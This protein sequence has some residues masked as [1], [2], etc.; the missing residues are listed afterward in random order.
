MPRVIDVIR[1]LPAV[2]PPPDADAPEGLSGDH[3]MRRITRAVAFDP[4]GWTAER[5]AEVVELFD[6]L[7]DEWSSRDV[8]G[9]EAP[10]VDALD[11]GMAAASTA[12]AG[13]A[14]R[15][16]VAAATTMEVPVVVMGEPPP[17]P[18]TGDWPAA[19]RRSPTADDLLASLAEERSSAPTSF[20]TGPDATSPS[21]DPGAAPGSTTG[22]RPGPAPPVARSVR[23]V[24]VDVGAAIGLYSSLLTD[25][26][27]TVVSADIS[28]EM[29]RLAPPGPALRVQ[30]DASRLPM[31][32]GGVDVLV[33]ANA[34]LFP[35]EV[36][37]TLAAEGVVVW[38]SSHGAET[39][40]HL[41]ADEVDQA[42]PGEWDGVSSRAGWG[43]WS[44]HWRTPPG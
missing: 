42:L 33:L 37:R 19:D 36:E 24:C 32:G 43:T 18:L 22:D 2:I 25:R 7:A 3:P 8:P 13:P 23:R 4:E 16:A 41:T 12:A 21:P 9:R 31:V 30:T 1:D 15:A 29:L 14:L 28:A 11:R 17:V 40:I 44:V 27:P 35:A 34:F 38:V 5:Q 10:L 39:P 6:R 26:F 20:D